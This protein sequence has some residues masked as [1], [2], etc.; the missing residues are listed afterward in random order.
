MSTV[1]V[2]RDVN[3]LINAM[4]IME[5]MEENDRLE[6][7]IKDFGMFAETHALGMVGPQVLASGHLLVGQDFEG[8]MELKPLKWL[9]LNGPPVLQLKV[10][11]A[12]LGDATGLPSLGSTS[13]LVNAWQAMA[14]Q[15]Q[16]QPG[17]G[18]PVTAGSG[19]PV[20]SAPGL[21]VGGERSGVPVGVGSGVPEC[22]DISSEPAGSGNRTPD[23]SVLGDGGAGDDAAGFGVPV[24]QRGS[25]S[26]VFHIED[27]V[28][29][30]CKPND[31][32]RQINAMQFKGGSV[33]PFPVTPAC[34][35]A[36]LGAGFDVDAGEHM[37]LW[38]PVGDRDMPQG[39]DE[40]HD[41]MERF[42][43]NGQSNAH[44]CSG[45][46]V[47]LAWLKA[48]KDTSSSQ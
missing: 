27:A 41:V 28:F 1:P 14:T 38:G 44:W 13:L 24:S 37:A 10:R 21:Q 22:F 32:L 35:Y 42:A 12:K 47:C 16:S 17:I 39:L 31:C 25:T 9:A 11:W 33:Y 43:V 3:P 29:N 5:G 46:L 18:V 30:F 4:L 36:A 26:S 45:V 48:L 6:I 20:A 34:N 2:R 19:V 40:V 23:P 8:Y 15:P 7:R